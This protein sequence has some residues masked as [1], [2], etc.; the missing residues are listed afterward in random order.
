MC[1]WRCLNCQRDCRRRYEKA[2]ADPF[3]GD[4]MDTLFEDF[5]YAVRTLR[6]NP[7]FAAT[8]A[9]ALALGIGANTA[10]FSVLNTVLLKPLPYPE[11]DRL[12]MFLNTSPQGMFPGASPTKFN[13]WRRQTGAFQDIAAYRFNVVNLTNA[14]D[15]EQIS[16]GQV[17]ADF[18]RLFGAPLVAGRTFSAEEDRPDG[19]RVVVLSN[20]F[21]KRRCGRDGSVVSRM[22]SLNGLSHDVVGVLGRFDTEAIEP[23][24][25]A[26]DVWLP[27]QIDPDSRMQGHFFAAAGRL[28]PGTT[29]EA[30]NVQLQPA[31]NEFRQLFP[32]TIGPQGGFGVQP[33]QEIIVRNVRSSLWILVGAVSFVLLIACA[34]VANLL[35]VRANVRQREIAI[36]SA[37][38]AGRGRIVRQLLTESVVLAL[39][40]GGCGLVLGTIGIRALLALNPGNIPRIGLGGSAVSIDG[41][42]LA[43]T[44]IVSV[45]TGLV[46]GLFPAWHASA[47]DLSSTIKEGGRSGSGLRQNRARALLVIAEMG[48]ALV[49]L[50][51]AAL[52]IRTF[53]ALRAVNPGFDSHRVLTMRMSL[54]G[55]RFAKAAAVGQLIRDGA[56][57][58]QAIPGIEVAGAA[59]CVPLEGGFGLPFIIEGR[60]LTTGPFHGGGGLRPSPRPV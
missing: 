53:L 38:G 56:E 9:G 2:A 59:C 39:V 31:A 47:T 34:N 21:W 57:R 50:V 12:V 13:V 20:G 33:L 15:P 7:A 54:T 45:V 60:P 48:L 18:F 17:S 4:A 23:P 32:N 41:R 14:G 25:G 11:P 49:L 27:F 28:R 51:G 35:L 22:I 6:P 37:L 29:L 55:A 5:R 42:V 10:I 8:A 43:F 30:A 58:L 26:P 16:A 40:G 3:R 46:F 52:L 44:A 36:R 24:T 1:R 19:G